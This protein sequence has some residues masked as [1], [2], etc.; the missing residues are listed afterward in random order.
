MCCSSFF[1][2]K[3]EKYSDIRDKERLR[4]D[5][6][7]GGRDHDRDRDRERDRDRDRDRDD[8]QKPSRDR[9]GSARE[10]H[11]SPTQAV[12]NQRDSSYDDRPP[13]GYHNQE[14]HKSKLGA[15]HYAIY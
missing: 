7:G 13:S 9:K 5:T 3:D 4:K 15:G 1:F 11:E 2:R 8:Q 12:W 10:K 6:R 14:H